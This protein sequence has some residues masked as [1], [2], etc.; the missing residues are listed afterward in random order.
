MFKIDFFPHFSDATSCGAET[1]TKS[2]LAH[3]N[4]L[5]PVRR[6]KLPQAREVLRLSSLLKLTAAGRVAADGAEKILLNVG[7]KPSLKGSD[8][9][10][11]I[12]DRDEAVTPG[13]S[14][15]QRLLAVIQTPS[16]DQ[17]LH[18]KQKHSNFT[19]KNK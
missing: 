2:A 17:K 15:L 1:H 14:Q 19:V 10:E 5:P 4:H 13:L 8:G 9:E 11:D 16:C 12:G 18:P 7:E 3:S 6:H